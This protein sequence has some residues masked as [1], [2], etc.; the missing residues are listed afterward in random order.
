MADELELTDERVAFDREVDILHIRERA[1]KFDKGHEGECYLCGEW[2]S[3][4]IQVEHKTGKMI[5]ACG[6]CRDKYG[7]K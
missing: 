5:D 4:V 7:L 2:M 3:R 1:A 6:G